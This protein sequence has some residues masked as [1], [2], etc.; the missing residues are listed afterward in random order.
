MAIG[1]R[2][3]LGR[4]LAEVETGAEHPRLLVGADRQRAAADPGREPEEVPDE[5][6][7]ARLASER[8]A[9]EHERPQ[10]FR[11]RVD[12]G[13]EAGRASADDH[14]V[15]VILQ[16]R[17]VGSKSV[18]ELCVRGIDERFPVEHEHKGQTP[19]SHV[20]PG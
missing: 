17:G 8:F 19:A 20:S 18:G 13:A 14:H 2:A 4:A 12:G 5:R 6:R 11:C 9:L 7:C 3:Q 16:R 10:A 1:T 15:P